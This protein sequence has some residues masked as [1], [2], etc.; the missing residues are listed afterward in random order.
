[1]KTSNAKILAIE[2][3]T[4]ACSVALGFAGQ[5]F[6]RQAVGN[7]IHS[8]LL[9]GMVEEILQEGGLPAR[10]IDAVAV[11]K[12]PGSFTGLRIG[13]GVAQGLA[14][15]AGCP[16]IGVSSLDALAHM[17]VLENGTDDLFLETKLAGKLLAGTDARMGEIY[18]CCYKREE[19]QQHQK[20]QALQD[21]VVTKPAG[22][23]VPNDEKLILVGNAWE[24]YRSELGEE[25]FNNAVHLE[26]LLFPDALGVMALAEEKYLCGDWQAAVDFAPDYVR[27]NVAKKSQKPRPG[28]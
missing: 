5:T 10:D 20:W 1:M 7:N 25:F 14:Y 17:S 26:H 23:Q 11:G 24:A 13:V 15:G 6:H 3:A 22:L 12:G 19:A 21:Q 16:M 8:Q 18:W 2:T 9:L 28:K 4:N 27:N